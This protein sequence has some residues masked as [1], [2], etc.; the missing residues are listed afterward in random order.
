MIR[1]KRNKAR[2]IQRI[3]DAA[4]RRIVYEKLS[5]SEKLEL[6]SKRRGSSKKETAR[7]LKR[8]DD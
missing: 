5:D 8:I 3:Q 6:I 2:V 4:K 1:G 7:I